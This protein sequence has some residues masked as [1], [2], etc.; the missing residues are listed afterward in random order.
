VK[1]PVAIDRNTNVP[2]Q[3]LIKQEQF[4]DIEF[5]RQE[6]KH[7][8]Q[9]NGDL[10]IALE[11]IAE[12]GDAVEQELHETNA[13]LHEEITERQRAEIALQEAKESAEIAN[14]AKS[15]FLA[16]MSHELRTPLNAVLGFTQLMIGDRTLNVEQRETLSII[17]SSGEHL[18]LL[19]NDVLA[20]SKIEAGKITFNETTFDLYA[21]LNRLRDMLRLK[22]E[23]KEI[24]LVFVRSPDIPQYIQADEIKLSQVLINLLNNAIKFTEQG[25]VKLSINLSMGIDRSSASAIAFEISDTGIGIPSYDL[26]KVFEAFV[27]TDAG[28]KSQEGTGLG[29]PISRKFVQLMGGDIRVSSVLNE[30]TT[31]AFE[32]PVKPVSQTLLDCDRNVSDHDISDRSVSDRSVSDRSNNQ[33]SSETSVSSLRVL[34]AEDNIVNQKVAVRMLERLGYSTDIAHNGLEVLDALRR[35]PYDLILMDIQMPEMDGIEATCSICQEWEAG[36]RPVIIAMTA[37]AMEEERDRC[38]KAGMDD[39]ISKPVRL[40]ELRTMLELWSRIRNRYP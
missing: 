3:D 7:L 20:L 38:L 9:T 8:R 30:G 6:I 33:V 14:R 22:A 19:I 37:N 12:H 39:H 5:L 13:R 40:E 35:Q 17:N 15:E 18:L 1:L 4:D 11:T 29:L 10:Q 26:D 27:Q 34:L 16:N 23:A 25:E 2:D 31:F 36:Q 24:S 21:L 32:I 28:R